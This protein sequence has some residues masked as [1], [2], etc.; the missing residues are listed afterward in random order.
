MLVWLKRN[1]GYLVLIL[2]LG[3]IGLALVI[4]IN[5]IGL[6]VDE[7]PYFLAGDMYIRWYVDLA[8][9][10]LL[11]KW[12]LPIDNAAI[13][14]FWEF[15][16]EHPPLAKVLCGVTG[17]LERLGIGRIAAHRTG[18]TLLFLGGLLVLWRFMHEHYGSAAAFA[19]V[20]GL[21]TLPQVFAHAHLAVLDLPFAL[22]SLFVVTSMI[23]GLRSRWAMAGSGVLFGVALATKI[24]AL[25]LPWSLLL[26][27]VIYHRNR[28]TRT[29][30]AYLVIGPLTLFCLW[31]WLWHDSAQRLKNYIGFHVKHD[32]HPTWYWGTVYGDPPAPWHFAPVMLAITT[33]PIVLALAGV[34]VYRTI[35]RRDR[36]GYLLI[37]MLI[38]PMLPV[39]LPAA[40][41]YDGIRLFM[42]SA[43]FLAALA[44][45]GVPVVL[46]F[47]LT[48]RII[49]RYCASPTSQIALRSGLLA[50]MVI[51][52]ASEVIAINPHHLSYYNLLIGGERGALRAG[53]ESTFWGEANGPAI[54]QYLNQTLP[55]NATLEINTEAF[56]TFPE[57]QH[58]GMLRSDL[59][60]QSG[61]EYWV[62]SCQQGYSADWWWNLYHDRHPQYATLKTFGFRG[63]PLVKIFHRVAGRQ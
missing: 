20:L 34:G 56:T 51:P 61:G 2:V 13:N 11:G 54:L 46:D 60:F 17:Q 58:V 28:V 3:S 37:L 32:L 53:M 35:R 21:S 39:A 30:C 9:S 16:H 43:V 24:N 44:G 15:N 6:C 42:T 22:C 26:W 36:L 12:K 55:P 25:A 7:P 18:A 57:Y 62:L 19:A 48:T 4:T 38:T 40:P 45:I 5:D 33:P 31:P 23:A 8:K 47:L 10:F 52:G 41:A 63:V 14:R 49:Q 50:L 59:A 1:Q 29:L 27:V